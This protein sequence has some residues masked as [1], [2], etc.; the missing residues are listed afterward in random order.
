MLGTDQPVI[1]H[2]LDIPFGAEALEGVRMELVDAAYPLV[3]GPRPGPGRRTA[4]RM[5]P[6]ASPRRAAPCAARRCC[7]ACV[8]AAAFA[9]GCCGRRAPR[10]PVALTL[11]PRHAGIIATTDGDVA[12]KDVDIAGV[13]TSA[14]PPA[15]C[16]SPRLALC[17]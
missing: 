2:L 5:E 10:G 8:P 17:L 1:L 12:T 13:A 15:A 6:A 16:R 14:C 3:K 4:R 7:S 11:R 9:D